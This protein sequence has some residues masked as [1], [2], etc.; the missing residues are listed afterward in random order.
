[1]AFHGIIKTLGHKGIYSK[2]GRARAL[3]RTLIGSFNKPN[4]ALL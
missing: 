4:I 2:P 3:L 1:M